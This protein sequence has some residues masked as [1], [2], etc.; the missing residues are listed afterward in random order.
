M[1]TDQRALLMQRLE[2]L[3]AKGNPH[4]FVYWSR[5]LAGEDPEVVTMSMNED[6]RRFLDATEPLRQW[7][8][9]A[10]LLPE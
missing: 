1:D 9:A 10:G 3:V 5:L 6:L 7:M 2:P 8:V 4:A